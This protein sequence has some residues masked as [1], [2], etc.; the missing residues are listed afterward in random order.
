MAR[1]HDHSF[2]PTILDF[3]NLQFRSPWQ[4]SSSRLVSVLR[5]TLPEQH[6]DEMTHR[7]HIILSGTSTQAMQEH[8]MLILFY[9]SNKTKIDRSKWIL[10]LDILECS[11]IMSSRIL[12]DNPQ[13]TLLAAREALFHLAFDIVNFSMAVPKVMRS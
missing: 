9:L 12:A 7:T 6:L 13:F 10:V 3:E 2:V 11:G 1:L 8:L 5:G 4:L